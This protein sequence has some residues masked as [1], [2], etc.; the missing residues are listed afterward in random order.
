MYC[1]HCGTQLSE[2]AKFCYHCGAEVK[3]AQQAPDEQ[4]VAPV[5]EQENVALSQ[6]TVE[7]VAS[8]T[9]NV[10]TQAPAQ[11]PQIYYVPTQNVQQQPKQE[12]KT[13]KKVNILGIISLI[14][15]VMSIFSFES[16]F[17]IFPIA[18]V[19]LGI[20]GITNRKQ[21]DTCNGL[22]I[23]G[24]IVSGLML[25]ISWIFAYVMMQTYVFN[26]VYY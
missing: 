16:M 19:I 17:L 11:V 14:C 3:T 21:Y 25:V 18:G 12:D 8:P 26:P 2:N 23:A 13:N 1:Y 5:V 24:V 4:T 6:P 9:Q 22:A 20:L 7:Q 15:G 10:A